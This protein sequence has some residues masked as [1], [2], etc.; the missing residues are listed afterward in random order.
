MKFNTRKFVRTLV[1][2]IAVALLATMVYLAMFESAGMKISDAET[3]RIFFFAWS[4][5]LVGVLFINSMQEEPI[6]LGGMGFGMPSPNHFR[7][8]G[9][10]NAKS[11]TLFDDLDKQDEELFGAFKKE[12]NDKTE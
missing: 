4:M 5:T 1:T 2:T 8:G 12:E 9:G 6:R 7:Y 10:F 3:M 11:S